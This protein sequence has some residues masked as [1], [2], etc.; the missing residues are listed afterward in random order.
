MSTNSVVDLCYTLGI[1]KNI[2]KTLPEFRHLHS[3]VRDRSTYN[4]QHN[5]NYIG[6]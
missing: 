1:Y 3:K 4:K 5:E 6:A 2:P